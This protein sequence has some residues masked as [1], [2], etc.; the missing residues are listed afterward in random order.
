MKDFEAVNA[1]S[2]LLEQLS[3]LS[4]HSVVFDFLDFTLLLSLLPQILLFS[5]D[6]LCILKPFHIFILCVWRF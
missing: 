5:S 1:C 2:S 3:T 4:R 6:I